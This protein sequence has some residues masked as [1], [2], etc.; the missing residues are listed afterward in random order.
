MQ[1]RGP[2]A[3]VDPPLRTK[4]DQVRLWEALNYGIIDVIASDHAPY[5]K[6]EKEMGWNNIYNA[7][8]GGVV[9]ET[10]L[11]L[12]LDAVNNDKIDLERLVDV[13]STNPAQMNGLYP[14]KGD[15]VLGA[16]ADIVIC[17]MDKPF[18][19]KGENLHTI[20]KITPYEDIQ[21]KGMP[22]MT[23]VRGKVIF[24]DEQVAGKPGYGV[25]Q[26]PLE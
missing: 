24:E 16:D 26:A 12:M 5:T 13:F 23:L 9:I 22:V 10:T 14:K 15:I 21:G 11:P 17:D 6:E 8:S 25:F 2:Y 3:K 18:Q 20:Q 4:D 19:I 1:E 7:P